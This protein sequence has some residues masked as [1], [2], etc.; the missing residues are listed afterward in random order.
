M[1]RYPLYI[2]LL[3]SL[4]VLAEN[5]LPAPGNNAPVGPG[6]PIPGAAVIAGIAVAYGLYR[7]IKE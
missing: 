4:S 7:K 6:L 3:F 5:A 1:K 2:A